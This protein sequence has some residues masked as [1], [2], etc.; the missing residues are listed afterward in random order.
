VFSSFSSAFLEKETEGGSDLSYT[1][2]L[3]SV[4]RVEEKMMGLKSVLANPLNL[5]PSML[6]K[7][8]EEV[9]TAVNCY[10][11]DFSGSS[12]ARSYI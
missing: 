6:A 1:A 7:G 9:Q 12:V 5:L 2:V 11:L 8:R 4:V 3:C 10:E